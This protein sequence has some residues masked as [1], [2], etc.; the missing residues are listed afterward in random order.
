[1]ANAYFKA[2]GGTF[3]ISPETDE[4]IVTND[5]TDATMKGGYGLPCRAW[6][7]V[8]PARQPFCRSFVGHK[9]PG[10]YA[11]VDRI[12]GYIR[13][14]PE[15]APRNPETFD[16]DVSFII[17]K[18]KFFPGFSVSESYSLPRHFIR[19]MPDGRARVVEYVESTPEFRDAVSLSNVGDNSVKGK[20]TQCLH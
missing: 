7:K 8:S 16:E 6:N 3:H 1:L 9:R 13:M 18:D 4:V 19:R 2:G 20:S 11:I 15:Y 17:E 10:W 5:I 14:E 12:N